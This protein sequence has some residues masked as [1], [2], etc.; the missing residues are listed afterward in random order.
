MLARH[1]WLG[2]DAS[3]PTASSHCQSEHHLRPVPSIRPLRIEDTGGVVAIYDRAM[4]VEPAIGPMSPSQWEGFLKQPQN[5]NGEDFRVAL[6]GAQLVGHAASYLRDH[7]R[8]RAR[9]CDLVVAPAFRRQGVGSALMDSLL[10]IDQQD[11]NLSFQA[12]AAHDWTA[13]IAFL[14]TLGFSYV[15]SDLDMRCVQLVPPSDA[16]A[17]P[18]SSERV[19]Q[20]ASVAADVARIHNDAYRSDSGSRVFTPD[21]MAVNISADELWVARESGQILAFCRIGLGSK[22]A[23]I[24][25]LAVHP[26]YHGRGIGKTLTYHALQFLGVGRDRSAGL[27]VSSTNAGARAVYARLGFVA[28]REQRRF[29][30]LR[31]DLVVVMAL[32][33]RHSS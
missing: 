15:E 11:D 9:F 31:K 1:I 17:L 22:L 4:A 8:E 25:S 6:S 33:R 3:S 7:G 29:S 32:R 2:G 26:A 24:K 19:A 30:K 18:I 16:L 14:T 12:V 10:K 13:G 5:R 23:W 27:T 21:E 20:P 28:R